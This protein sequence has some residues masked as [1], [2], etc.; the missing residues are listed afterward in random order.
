MGFIDS[1]PEREYQTGKN[2]WR[3][4]YFCVFCLEQ[5]LVDSYKGRDA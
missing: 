2:I 3:H 5:V 4:K 1:W